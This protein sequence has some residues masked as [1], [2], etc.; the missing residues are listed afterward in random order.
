MAAK[1]F[2]DVYHLCADWGPDLEAKD[3]EKAEEVIYG[4]K[5]ILFSVVPEND[6]ERSARPKGPGAR[7][8]LCQMNW[9]GIGKR[10]ICALA[11]NPSCYI[12]DATTAQLLMRRRA[13]VGGK[14]VNVGMARLRKKGVLNVGVASH[15]TEICWSSRSRF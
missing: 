9:D 3:P 15:F 2:N 12:A 5:M 7:L 4:I 1:Y 11:G 6:K 8:W 13:L 14:D 10:E